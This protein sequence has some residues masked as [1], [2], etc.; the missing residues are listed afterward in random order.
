[1]ESVLPSNK[2]ST[3][4]LP[5][6]SQ[7]HLQVTTVSQFRAAARAQ[8]RQ[9]RKISSRSATTD[10]QQQAASQMQQDRSRPLDVVGFVAANA[11][12]DGELPRPAA[13]G[14]LHTCVLYPDASV[15]GIGERIHLQST[16]FEYYVEGS[17]NCAAGQSLALV[18]QSLSLAVRQIAA[19]VARAGLEGLYG[20]AEQQGDGSGDTQKKL[21]IIAVSVSARAGRSALGGLRLLLSG[22]SPLS[23]GERPCRVS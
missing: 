10:Q 4:Q 17:N 20:V 19:K 7:A 21:D 16:S 22:M 2:L 13:P 15:R 23:L 6:S 9:Q 14:I 3:L 8:A 5:C 18:F 11:P 1:M 12:D